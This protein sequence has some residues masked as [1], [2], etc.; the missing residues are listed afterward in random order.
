MI[1]RGLC[2][3]RSRSQQWKH[4]INREQRDLL[5]THPT[6][7]RVY[8]TLNQRELILSLFTALF[9]NGRIEIAINFI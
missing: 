3:K 9:V 8:E 6:A 7:I 5:L 2:Q 4:L 1:N